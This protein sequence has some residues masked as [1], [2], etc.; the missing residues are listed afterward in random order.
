MKFAESKDYIESLL[1]ELLHN[2]FEVRVIDKGKNKES[3][4]ILIEPPEYERQSKE[5][6][7]AK[8]NEILEEIDYTY[9]K[10]YVRNNKLQLVW[11]E[12]LKRSKPSQVEMVTLK[13]KEKSTE[14]E[15]QRGAYQKAIEDYTQALKIDP[16][17]LQAYYNR[18]NAKYQLGQ[19]QDAIEDYTQAFQID[20][21]A[22]SKQF[23]T[24]LSIQFEKLAELKSK[25]VLS[26]E[27][28]CVLFTKLKNKPDEPKKYL[29][30]DYTYTQTEAKMYSNY[31]FILKLFQWIS[32][33]GSIILAGGIIQN[34]RENKGFYYLILTLTF[35]LSTYI[36]YQ[37]LIAIIDL[38][39]NIEFNTRQTKKD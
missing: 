38:L 10:I 19:Y 13:Q 31:V 37:T 9:L 14:S 1:K 27:E 5:V 18:A 29:S 35:W 28:F 39:S 22:T 36:F 26:D 33:G 32:Y 34:I 15:Q 2:D 6:I 11:T 30:E 21:S 20:R 24:S 23:P 17:N 12:S 16:N 4:L 8:L 3:E 25:G 7:L